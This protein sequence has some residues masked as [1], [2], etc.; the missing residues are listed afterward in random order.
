MSVHMLLSFLKELRKSDKCKACQA[1]H[2]FIATS[3]LNSLIQEYECKMT[4][5]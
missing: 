4:L 2:S 1:F 5:R 3:K